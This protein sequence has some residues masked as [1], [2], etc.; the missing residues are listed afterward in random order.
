MVMK[1]PVISVLLPVYNAQETV[2]SAVRSIQCQTLAEFECIIIDDGSTDETPSILRDLARGDDRLRIHSTRNQGIVAA[3]N[4]GIEYCSAPLIARMDGDDLCHPRRLELQAAY[5]KGSPEVSVCSSRIAMFPRP[6]VRGG[7]WRYQEWLNGMCSHD[8]IVR[9]IFI[10]SPIAH[11]SAVLRRE[12][13]LEMGGYRE[14]GWP[15]DYDLWLRYYLAG[16]RFAKL[17]RTILAWRHSESRLTFADPRYSVES[18]LRAKAH[19]LARHLRGQRRPLHL[20]GAGKT[21]ARLLKHLQRAGLE[22][23]AIIDI[24]PRKIGRTKRGVPVLA[25][26]ELPG[27]RDAFVISAVG[28]AGARVLIRQQ[29]NE[30]GYRESQDF[31]CAA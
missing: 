19:Y 15:E 25:Q 24:D 7:M 20:W 9:N 2:R 1:I 29:L 31:I 28:S 16:R 22:I 12:E 10:E 13:L 8:D 23:T 14:C 21:G 30:R 17:P 4:T 5:M 27:P 11:P 3:L 26:E 18:F 6:E